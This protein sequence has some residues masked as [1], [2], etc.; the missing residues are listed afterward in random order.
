MPSTELFLLTWLVFVAVGSVVSALIVR[1]PGR[2]ILQWDPAARHRALVLLAALPVLTAAALM[3]SAILPSLLSLELP[4]F[5]HCA[6]HNDGHPHLCFVHLPRV[7]MNTTAIG[8][9]VLV[10]AAAAAHAVRTARRM[11]RASRV[12]R[13]LALSGDERGDLG[14]TIVETPQ[15]VCLAAGLL[16]PRVLLS[17]GLLD[18]LTG[19]EQAIVLAHER[20]HVRRRDALVASVVRALATLHFPATRRWLIR[21]LDIAAEQAC[22]EAAGETLGDRVAVA[23]AILAVKRAGLNAEVGAL[24]PVA[25]SFGEQA[26]ERRVLSLLADP[27]PPR[28]VA[29]LAAF[30]VL[31]TL[32]L[33][34]ASGQLHHTV[35]SLLFLVAY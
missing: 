1:G 21:E 14:A 12:L 17:R 10:V 3:L 27:S 4:S 6:V 15:P 24:A 11:A 5:D 18:V 13:M 33:L 25:V 20:A 28:S 9:L 19:D 31:A 30:F 32:G 29:A 2:R 7:G 26:A 35:E 16:H 8:L 22:D 34:V 23:S